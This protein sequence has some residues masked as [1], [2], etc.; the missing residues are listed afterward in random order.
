MA[1]ALMCAHL[2]C[3]NYMLVDEDDDDQTWHCELHPSEGVF[4]KIGDGSISAPL[5][6]CSDRGYPRDLFN[7]ILDAKVKPMPD[8]K[9]RRL[10][11]SKENAARFVTLA[12]IGISCGLYHPIEWFVNWMKLLPG[13][14]PP[15][16]LDEKTKLAEDVFIEFFRNTDREPGSPIETLDRE[17]LYRMVSDFADEKGLP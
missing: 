9:V 1:H 5:P 11:M 16:K 7:R 13:L 2:G 8:E 17:G 14:T 6:G 10:E 3:P 15:E 4:Q 12:Q